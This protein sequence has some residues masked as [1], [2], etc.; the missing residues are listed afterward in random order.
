[1]TR[2]SLLPLSL[3]LVG[4]TGFAVADP[5]SKA[6]VAADTH[7]FTSFTDEQAD[8]ALS[9]EVTSTPDES[10]ITDSTIENRSSVAAYNKKTTESK[11]YYNI[12]NNFETWQESEIS[13]N[14][15][16]VAD[17]ADANPEAIIGA[18][19]FSATG[20]E[21][22][23]TTSDLANSP[24]FERTCDRY[25]QTEN[26]V[27]VETP[28]IYVP[29]VQDYICYQG[30]G[31]A[32]EVCD[33][34]QVH[35]QCV[36]TGSF[37]LEYGFDD[38][39]KT[40]NNYTCT[41]PDPLD[42]TG[43]KDG[44][45]TAGEPEITW[46]LDCSVGD[47]CVRANRVCTGEE[48]VEFV[49]GTAVTLEC[50]EYSVDYECPVDGYVSACSTF[51]ESDSCSVLSSQCVSTASDGACSLYEDVYQCGSAEGTTETSCE[52]VN[53]CVNDTCLPVETD[54]NTDSAQSLAYVGILNDMANN[55]YETEAVSGKCDPLAA[56]FGCKDKPDEPGGILSFFSADEAKCRKSIAGFL[57]C[58]K[59]TGWG[60]G[61]I[62]DCSDGELAL[63]QAQESER[64]RYTHT[65]CSSDTL[66]GCVE[67]KRVY[68]VY[69]SK[70]A[71]VINS[72]VQRVQDMTF[73]CRAL[74][75]EEMETV[76]WDLVDLTPV[77]D[78]MVED[79]D[80][81]DSDVLID[82]LQNNIQVSVPQTQELYE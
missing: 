53:V 58:C 17:Q 38:C 31:L 56:L 19:I 1:M 45:A 39:D 23:C 52:S 77:F 9:I 57:N 25:R 50:S 5:V 2:F 11:I 36:S 34:L 43:I 73:E 44:P 16:S 79:L 71:L 3:A 41:S 20:N 47:M 75:Q 78:D 42:I 76:N 80:I 10:D 6:R 13:D 33:E 60:V 63:Y 51:E 48:T 28:D 54:P 22:L 64:A 27:C 74:T 68:C 8:A 55:W 61:T 35:S 29:V 72:E 49:D 46:D 82:A 18:D 70:L 26:H 30:D 37:C 32:T 59:D 24:L 65:Y 69:G 66:F 14:Q 7:A 81:P 62:T 67:K 4:I 40:Q 12:G 21:L 15:F